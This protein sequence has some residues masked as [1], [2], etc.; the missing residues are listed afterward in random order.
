MLISRRGKKVVIFITKVG[1]RISNFRLQCY[2]TTERDDQTRTRCVA[3]SG[4]G[5]IC[6]QLLATTVRSKMNL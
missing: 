4:G 2:S 5:K 3:I 1:I 6:Y